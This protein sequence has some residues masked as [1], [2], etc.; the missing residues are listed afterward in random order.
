MKIKI[1]FATILTL[2][3]FTAGYAQT[4]DKAK[5]D[6]FFD[7][8]DEKHKAMGSLTIAKDGNVLYSRAIGYSQIN[9]TEKKPLTAE[10]RFRI[11]S[12]TKMF[13]ATLILQLVD[14]GKLKLS[15]TVDKFLPQIPNAGKITIAQILS[16]RSG[17]PNVKRERDTQTKVSTIPMTK[18]DM[19][20][21]LVKATPDFEP[22][23]KYH[24]SNSGYWVLG[25]ILEKVMAKAYDEILKERITSKIGLKDTYLTTGNIDANKNEAFTYIHFGG[26]WKPVSETHPTILFSAGAI[27]STPADMA[28]FIQAL[29]DGKLVSKPTLDQ[30]TT[31]RDAEGFGMGTFKFAGKTFYGHTGGADNYGAWLAYEPEEKLVI[32]YAT[33][34]KIYPVE[35]IVRGVADIYYHKPFVIPALESIAVDPDVLDRYVGVYSSPDAPAKPTIT[36]DG[37]T[38]FFQPPG[39]SSAVPLEATAEDK[40]QIE[41]AAVFTFDPAKNQMTVKRRNGMERVF[42]KEK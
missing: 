33:N 2:A 4:L 13:T 27:V 40:F 11:G 34:A 5:L 9:G 14:E 18:D 7:R 21:L 36:R 16:H 22:D 12:I 23:T 39:A 41:G 30:M 25:F 3:L 29:F 15:D 10:N 17:I 20:A 26:D 31:M 1:S 19:L 42:T 35:S 24:Y 37:L 28:K 8:L 6:Q 38:L 32:A